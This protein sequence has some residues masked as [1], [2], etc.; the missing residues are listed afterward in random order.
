MHDDKPECKFTLKLASPR[1]NQT[2]QQERCVALSKAIK[3]AKLTS[4][5]TKQQRCT[6]W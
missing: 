4:S 5:A 2:G 3:L 1:S 6:P